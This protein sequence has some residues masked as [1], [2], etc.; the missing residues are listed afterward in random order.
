MLRCVI[1]AGA[2][3]LWE[4]VRGVPFR[5]DLLGLTIVLDASADT[6]HLAQCRP[7]RRGH[8]GAAF[9]PRPAASGYEQPYKLVNRC[10]QSISLKTPF[11]GV[12]APCC[13]SENP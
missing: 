3:F 4:M 9:T 8:K 12:G 5:D 10:Y 7:T 2:L 1:P 13:R 11:K 6:A